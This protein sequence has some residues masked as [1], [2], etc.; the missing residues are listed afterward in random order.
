MEVMRL[1]FDLTLFS[2]DLMQKQATAE[3]IQCNDYTAR[4]GLTLSR[5]QAAELV[6]TRFRSL[7][8]NGR[9]EFGGGAI[10]KIIREF[11]DS[12]YL[13]AGNYAD[14]LHELTEIFYYYKNETLDLLPDEDL[15]RA[16]KSA[17]DGSC[18]G[19]LELLR[20]R[21]MYRLARRIRYG[22]PDEEEDDDRDEEV[23][24]E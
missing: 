5:T 20:E 23:F 2:H 10:D 8:D 4:Y 3:V 13:S 18:R 7:S 19:S 9:V 16:M 24:D 6:E 21:E 14:T 15:I 12:P 11:C 17:F 1:A 22:L